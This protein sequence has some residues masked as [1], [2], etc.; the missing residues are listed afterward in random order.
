MIT[1]TLTHFKA[2][3]KVSIFTDQKESLIINLKK[4][5]YN[6]YEASE[7]SSVPESSDWFDF[8]DVFRCKLI[9]VLD[10]GR[11]NLKWEMKSTSWWFCSS[12]SGHN[13]SG[14]ML[15]IAWQSEWWQIW[16]RIW[17]ILIR[18]QSQKHH[19]KTSSLII[20]QTNSNIR[21]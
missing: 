11:S 18:N 6:L 1:K 14:F 13:S 4:E 5:T 20:L 7:S 2:T 15:F 3:C 17:K 21:N 19:I 8:I 9:V 10:E 16:E 12:H